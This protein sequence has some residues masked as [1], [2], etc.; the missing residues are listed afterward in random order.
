[1]FIFCG[2]ISEEEATAAIEHYAFPDP[3]VICISMKDE[4]G[5]EIYEN[6]KNEQIGE[7]ISRWIE[8]HHPGSITSLQTDG[9][10]I[11]G[12]WWSGVEATD[13][14]WN[15]VEEYAETLPDS[16]RNKAGTWLAILEDTF[17]LDDPDWLDENNLSLYAAT[18]CEWL[19]GFEAASGNGFNDFEAD[20]V[21]S[22]LK[23]DD[24]YLGYLL[25]QIENATSLRDIFDECDT[26]LSEL[27]SYALHRATEEERSTVRRALVEF[28]GSDT[29]LFW[30]LQS[31]IWP[32]FNEPSQEAC[33]DLVNPH[34]WE[35][36]AEVIG[37]WNFVTDGW[38]DTA[39]P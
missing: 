10:D 15:F 39:N 24:L 30:A 28:F 5:D 31:A 34:T 18:L 33:Y 26:D 13:C 8:T 1:L 27:R 38:T 22:A 11:D 21:A 36:V 12:L 37:S 3:K 9:Y 35:G 6:E 17:G 29:A 25:C 23:M 20:F 16:H 4:D 14:N 7:E 19:H 2:E 32:R